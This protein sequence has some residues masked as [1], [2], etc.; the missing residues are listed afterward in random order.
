MFRKA[1]E[2][3]DHDFGLYSNQGK[4]QY[5]EDRIVGA[6]ELISG[7]NRLARDVQATVLRNH[8]NQMQNQYANFESIGSTACVATAWVEPDSGAL[9]VVTANLGDSYAYLLI[10]N[11][12]TMK[13]RRCQKLTHAHRPES[14]NEKQRI[15]G[16]NGFV[17]NGRLNGGLAMSR[18][19]GDKRY[20]HFGLSHVPDIDFHDLELL[21]TDAAFIIVASDGLD[22]LFSEDY[23]EAVEEFYYLRHIP[24]L[25][26]TATVKMIVNMAITEYGSSDNCTAGI[27]RV[28]ETPLSAAVFDGHGGDDVAEFMEKFFYSLLSKH[29]QFSLLAEE[30]SADAY[31]ADTESDED[32]VSCDV[33]NI[34]QLNT[35]TSSCFSTSSTLFAGTSTCNA[36][37]ILAVSASLHKK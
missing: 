9:R 28:K 24:Y 27:F 32:A 14:F 23:C 19:F 4:R 33:A 15:I 18:A 1:P 30:E 10:L 22:G 5:Q 2:C 13:V 12:I 11:T 36:L 3:L 6:K 21:E 20:E 31:A 8:F 17:Q 16:A 26:L 29:I 35:S 37:S 25:Q 7:F 34:S